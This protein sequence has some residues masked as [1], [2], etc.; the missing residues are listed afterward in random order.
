MICTS[1]QNDP[2]TPHSSTQT[3]LSKVPSQTTCTAFSNTIPTLT[4]LYAAP[5][6]PHTAC[7]LLSTLNR[8]ASRA[9]HSLS[10]AV[11]HLPP[12]YP[13][14]GL[15]IPQ[16]AAT[17]ARGREDQHKSC[18]C[19]RVPERHLLFPTVL[20]TGKQ[21]K[22]APL[23]RWWILEMWKTCC[24][25][26]LKKKKKTIKKTTGII[27][28]FFSGTTKALCRAFRKQIVKL[29]ESR[30]LVVENMHPLY[31]SQNTRSQQRT[32]CCPVMPLY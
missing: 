3:V 13:S 10:V 22:F 1:V 24:S 30:F 27:W 15:C 14:A 12:R 18:F 9:R 11:P 8:T 26:N 19:Y 25:E 5:S 4:G 6:L 21:T 16:T 31:F 2:Y 23:F 32:E 7:T 29:L 20:Q 28:P 17:S